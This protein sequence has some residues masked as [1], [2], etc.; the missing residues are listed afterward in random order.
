MASADCNDDDLCKNFE[1]FCSFGAAAGAKKTTMPTKGVNKIFKDCKLYGKS[2]T[3][4]D[5]DI[6]FSKVCD[7]GK[8]EINL[9]QF[10]ALV[11]ELSGKYQ[12]DHKLGSKEEAEKAILSAVAKK[13]PSTAGTTGTSK[14][15]GVAKMTDSSQYTGAHKERFD[16]SGKGKGIAGREDKSDGSGYVGNYKGSGTFD[17]KK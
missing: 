10:K 1:A 9:K 12:K 8:K 16:G 15:G 13:G 3:T 4:T 5:T 2:L 14:T 17:K 6:T 11:T 7:K